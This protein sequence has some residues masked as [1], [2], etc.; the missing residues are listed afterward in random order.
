MYSRF[1]SP[2]QQTSRQLRRKEKEATLQIHQ[3]KYGVKGKSKGIAQN[4][5]KGINKGEK[6]NLESPPYRDT[7]SI[8]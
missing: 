4:Q 1:I 5:E 2:P 6:T 3:G 8:T 7:Y